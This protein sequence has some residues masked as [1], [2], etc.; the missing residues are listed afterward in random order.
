[1]VS[2]KKKKTFWKANEFPVIKRNAKKI[3][4]MRNGN[5]WLWDYVYPS[6]QSK[7]ICDEVLRGITI[8]SLM[9]NRS[10]LLCF[11]IEFPFCFP[12][13]FFFLNFVLISKI[14][15][16]YFLNCR[17]FPHDLRWWICWCK[18]HFR[19]TV[20]FVMRWKANS[21]ICFHIF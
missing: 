12:K 11:L 16:F 2:I 18:L 10:C 8:Q 4:K 13:C 3:N 17:D 15:K 6:F 19:A 7:I 5:H 9:A 21:T 20:R 1:M 14:Y